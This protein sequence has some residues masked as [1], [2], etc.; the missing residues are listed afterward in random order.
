MLEIERN[1]SIQI[2]RLNKPEKL[3]AWN[4][5]ARESIRA[6]LAKSSTDDSVTAVVLTGT[7]PKAFC[8]GADLSDAGVGSASH[9][10]DRMQAFQDLYRTMQ[11][12]PKPLVCA[13]NGL[14]AGSAFQAI[15]LT[16][17]RIAHRGVK[18]G[19]PEVNQGLPCISG[20]MLMT[21][22]LGAVRARE[23]ALSGRF[24]EGEEALR[25]GLVD[26]LVEPDQ[27][28]PRAFAVAEAL[29]KKPAFGFAETKLWFHK[30]MEP[31]LLAAFQQA[32]DVRKKGGAE[33]SMKSGVN[34]FFKRKGG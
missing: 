7:G 32:S 3:N 9:A 16:D 24:V 8:A 29:A 10:T 22:S 15:L 34:A 12:F 4:D 13:L 25:L 17:I 18:L 23:L 33:K 1:G 5:A 6:A 2:L 21:W 28:L 27:V 20:S 26:E 14:A 30:M 11:T 19:M 31:M